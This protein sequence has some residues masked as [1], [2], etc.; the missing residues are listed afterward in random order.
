MEHQ[1]FD[2]LGG[3]F[4]VASNVCVETQ[5]LHLLNDVLLTRFRRST[6]RQ[7]TNLAQEQLV[8]LTILTS[9]MRVYIYIYIYRCNLLSSVQWQFSGIP[10]PPQL[11]TPDLFYPI[12]GMG[13][14]SG[15]GPY[16]GLGVSPRTA[17]QN[18]LT[19]CYQIRC[20]GEL[21]KP[22]SWFNSIHRSSSDQVSPYVLRQTEAGS[23]RCDSVITHGSRH[24]ALV[25]LYM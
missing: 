20:K 19:I 5:T 24:K 9:T 17:S 21:V 12:L 10:P 6:I 8:L 2:S 25:I 1:Y 13:E 3:I 4:L 22:K 23:D 15:F 7:S 18:I 11:L 14:F 16:S